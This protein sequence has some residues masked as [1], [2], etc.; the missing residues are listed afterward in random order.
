VDTPF[1]IVLVSRSAPLFAP[2]LAPL[3]AAACLPDEQ[4][5]PPPP[6]PPTAS[7]AVDSA[8]PGEL[9][10]GDEEA[11]GFPIPREMRVKAKMDDT[12]LAEGRLHQEHVANYVRD[13]VD[14]SHVD[15]GPTKTVFREA[16]LKGDPNHLYE[17]E[18]AVSRAG[19]ALIV[20]NRTRKPA[21]PGLSEKQRWEQVGM[22]PDGKVIENKAE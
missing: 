16:R 5:A 3:L 21:E 22:T 20:R 19:T 13:R 9:A 2:L 1:T 11:F 10:E 6:A 17:I 18:V 15:T 14:A 8:K 4:P 7:V 12:W